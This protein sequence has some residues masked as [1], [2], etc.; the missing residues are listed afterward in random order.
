MVFSLDPDAHPR[1]ALD[2]REHTRLIFILFADDRVNLPVTEFGTG[3]RDLRAFF[4]APAENLL[5]L[6]DSFWCRLFHPD[7]TRRSQVLCRSWHPKTISFR[8]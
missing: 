4:D 3:I 2:K 1:H 7:G 6:M 8:S 5:V